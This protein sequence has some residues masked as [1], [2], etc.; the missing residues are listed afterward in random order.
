MKNLLLVLVLL[1]PFLSGAQNAQIYEVHEVDSVAIPRGGYPYLTTFI[2]TNLQIPYM[3]KVAKVNGYVSLAG[4]VDEQGKI[5]EI[6]V[7][8]GIRSDCDKE[9]VRVFG[10]FNAWQAALKGG[11]AVRQKVAY[12][13]PF[14]STEE[15]TFVD[16]MQLTYFNEKSIKTKDSTNRKYVQKSQIDT[17][18]GFPIG[19]IEFFEIKKNNK[20]KLYATLS[21]KQEKIVNYLP[22]YPEPLQDSTIKRFRIKYVNDIGLITGMTYVFWENGHLQ[23]QRYYENNNAT[24]PFTTYYPN[25][26]VRDFTYYIDTTMKTYITKSWYPS[27]QVAKNIQYELP[28]KPSLLLEERDQ[29]IQVFIIDQWDEQGKKIVKNGEGNAFFQQY[30]DGLFTETGPVKNFQKHGIWKGYYD[31]ESRIA[32]KEYFNDGI[33]EKGISYGETDSVT[34]KNTSEISAEFQGGMRSFAKHLTT[35]LK[36]PS[37]AQ[38]ANAQGMSYIQFVVCTDG[39]LCD[40]KVLKSAGWNTLDEEAIRVIKASDGKWNPATQRGRKVRTKYTLPISFQL[41]GVFPK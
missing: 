33:L 14:K 32:Y 36:Y 10:L 35:T 31:E 5:S 3:A 37:D 38:R 39:S 15:I 40:Y 1:F 26:V 12:R 21:R 8:K 19:N 13:I 22:I 30:Q 6:E 7:I 29:N 16:G 2:N 34:Y 18:T 23:Q 20:E 4:V 9:A 41:G 28:S 11:K 25:G 27:G 24:F 17:L